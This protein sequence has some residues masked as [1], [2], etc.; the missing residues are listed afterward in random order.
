MKRAKV[1]MRVDLIIVWIRV[2]ELILGKVKNA[3]LKQAKNLRSLR[4]R[5]TQSASGTDGKAAVG[6]KFWANNSLIY[7]TISK[8]H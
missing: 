3:R 6:L 8:T 4:R 7:F 2:D 1:T 5:D